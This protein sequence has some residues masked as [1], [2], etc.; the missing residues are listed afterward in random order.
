MEDFEALRAW[1][2]ARWDTELVSTTEGRA[3]W[4]DGPT[5]TQMLQALAADG[6]AFSATPQPISIQVTVGTGTVSIGR[7]LQP[8]TAALVYLRAEGDPGEIRHLLDTD[9]TG[10]APATAVEQ[11]PVRLI[12]DQLDGHL[13]WWML[14]VDDVVDEFGGR[15]R[16]LADAALI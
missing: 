7:W 12:C 16:L 4:V 6:I 5:S 13:Q 3:R 1:A 2:S 10:M 14:E 9:V 15:D 8:E 11:I